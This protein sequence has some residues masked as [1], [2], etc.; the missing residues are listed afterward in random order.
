MRSYRGRCPCGASRLADL[1]VLPGGV[2]SIKKGTV[3]GLPVNE[4]LHRHFLSMPIV[5]WHK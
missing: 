5:Q 3:K 1:T 4:S 2:H